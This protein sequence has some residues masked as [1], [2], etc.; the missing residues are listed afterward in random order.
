MRVD[1]MTPH[2]DFQKSLSM[3]NGK[4]VL[5]SLYQSLPNLLFVGLMIL[6]SLAVH[7]AFLF[8]LLGGELSVLFLAQTAF[9]GRTQFEQERGRS[10]RAR[11]KTRTPADPES[12]TGW[13]A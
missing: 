3:A 13:L 2:A 7:P 5:K 6:F 9:V 11:A 12:N 10:G 8:I 1:I 4:N